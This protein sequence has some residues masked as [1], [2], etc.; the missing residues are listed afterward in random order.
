MM[1]QRLLESVHHASFN[2]R[3]LKSTNSPCF[4]L[5]TQLFSRVRDSSFS[6]RERVPSLC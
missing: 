1:K 5:Q 6:Y 4:I 2:S 3:L